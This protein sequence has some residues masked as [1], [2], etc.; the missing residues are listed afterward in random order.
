MNPTIQEQHP[1]AGTSG[2]SPEIAIKKVNA[3]TVRKGVGAHKGFAGGG[4]YFH[5]NQRS[6]GRLRRFWRQIAG[7]LKFQPR[8]LVVAV[9]QFRAHADRHPISGRDLIMVPQLLIR[10]I[11]DHRFLAA[12]GATDGLLFHGGPG[13]CARNAASSASVRTPRMLTISRLPPT[14]EKN[15]NARSKSSTRVMGVGA[16]DSIMSHVAESRLVVLRRR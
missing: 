16:D 11:A 10:L 15:T 4:S 14:N 13:Y 3:I 7:A 9:V 1:K 8:A 6:K 2:D 12:F 5:P